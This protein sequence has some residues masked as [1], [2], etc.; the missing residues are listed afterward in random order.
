[1]ST[2]KMTTMVDML[3]SPNTIKSDPRLHC[4]PLIQQL[5]ELSTGGLNVLVQG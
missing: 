4:L 5:L 1:M 3:L 2:H